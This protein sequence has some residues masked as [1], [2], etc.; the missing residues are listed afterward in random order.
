MA[1]GFAVLTVCIALGVKMNNDQ[2]N[3]KIEMV[4]AGFIRELFGMYF[5]ECGDIDGA[6][7]QELGEKHG[8]LVPKVY[9]APCDEFCNCAGF[10]DA[11][12]WADGVTCF[13]LADWLKEIR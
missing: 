1:I 6:D 9:Y 5:P 2:L 7:L 3:A 8:V 11:A 12:D 13:R 4:M 10:C